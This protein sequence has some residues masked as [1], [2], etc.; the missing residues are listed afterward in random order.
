MITFRDFVPGSDYS[1]FN[2]DSP[3][4]V[5]PRETPNPIYDRNS[6]SFAALNEKHSEWSRMDTPRRTNDSKRRRQRRPSAGG[7]VPL[8]EWG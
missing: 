3:S 4:T 1:N 5:K 7:V 6:I 8:G 2:G